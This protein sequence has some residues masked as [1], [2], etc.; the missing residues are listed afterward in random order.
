M[1]SLPLLTLTLLLTVIAVPRPTP[2]FSFMYVSKDDPLPALTF[3]EFK[4]D[5]PVTFEKSTN[6]PMLFVFWG[7]DVPEKKKRSIEVLKNIQASR[8][9]FD[10]RNITLAAINTQFDSPDE[11][12]EVMAQTNIDF[13]VYTD[14]NSDAIKKLGVFVMP[15]VLIINSAGIIFE[16]L[17][18]SRTLI[19]VISGEIQVMLNEKTRE[20]VEA[21][22]HPEVIVRTTAQRR[23]KIDYNYARNL[24]Q[25]KKVDSAIEKLHEA[26][27]KDAE[28]APA[29]IELGCLYIKQKNFV[30]AEKYLEEGLAIIPGFERGLTCREELESKGTTPQ[31]EEA[32]E[33][34]PTLDPGSWGFFDAGDDEEEDE[35]QNEG[36]QE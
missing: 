9:F 17:G 30:E 8:S 22:L 28:F 18:Y 15:S 1:Y 14:P 6:R 20:E 36:N 34:K 29:M 11:I 7:A 21:K 12:E 26:L 32:L 16:G 4:T 33:K 13:P 19:E 10:D 24:V 35:D 5:N 23:A 3:N 27:E 2:A 25:R 31:Q